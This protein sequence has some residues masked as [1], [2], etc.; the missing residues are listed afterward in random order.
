M[1]FINGHEVLLDSNENLEART[2]YDRVIW[3][4]MD[5]IKRCPRDPIN[6]LPWYLQYSCFWTDPLRPTVWPDNPAGKF[7]WAVTTLTKYYPYSG[8]AA[9]ID[10]V[11][12]MLD[13]LI[14][15]QTP[16]NFQ[17]ANTP[18]ASA[19]P[20]T[21][22]YFGARAD[23]EYAIEPDK[24]AQ[25]GRA[26]IDFYE[27]TGEEKYFRAGEDCAKA[28]LKNLRQGD[29]QR[30]PV[31]FRVNVRDG[32]VI[33][34][35][36]ADMVQLLRLFDELIRLGEPQYADARDRVM[37]WIIDYPLQNNVWKGYFEDIRLDPDNENRDQLTS[38]ETARYLLLTP[39]INPN[40]YE[41]ARKLID[42]VKVTL[43]AAP[44]FSALPIHEQKFCSHV[45]GSH[46]ARFAALCAAWYERSQDAQY[47]EMAIRSLN[48][49]TY[50]SS[51][52]GTVTVGV[53]RPDYYNQC[54][55]TD[56]YFDYVPHFLDVMASIPDCAPSDNDHLLRSST[57]VKGIEYRPKS[58]RYRTFD[59]T[60][61]QLLRLTFE[62]S[63]VLAGGK[64]LPQNEP[65]EAGAGWN[66]DRRTRVLHVT[67]N[68][69]D[70][71]ITDQL[72]G[73]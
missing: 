24:I 45:M 9:F 26:F 51:E 69:P 32:E 68:S 64:P 33:E 55:F 34:E 15:H 57:I 70:L 66:F 38:L 19:H 40:Q 47:R 13:R 37:Q 67:H 3:L 25:A 7:A 35:Y 59:P 30:S 46:T 52:D 50:M 17:W 4:A 16:S 8:D 18:Y 27:L 42:W 12:S 71:E 63:A 36:T 11:R 23:G 60:G 10:I 41:Q 56:G 28:L 54:W 65:G 73:G 49:A 5:F 44:F 58:I 21:G 48:W 20:G 1:Y 72:P 29:A 14:D 31:P 2:G 6:S 61:K 62:P 53:D 22:V 43:G 39:G